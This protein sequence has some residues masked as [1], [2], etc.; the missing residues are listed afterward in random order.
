MATTTEYLPFIPSDNNY[1]LRVVLGDDPVLIDVHWNSRDAAWY[2]DIY[3]DTRAPIAMGLKVVLGSPL[4]KGFQHV[5]FFQKH[6]LQVVDTSGAQI[7]AAYDDLGT[8]IQV[9]HITTAEFKTGGV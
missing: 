9:A 7:D 5:D 1:T 2:M 3:D 4:G 6:I 8:R